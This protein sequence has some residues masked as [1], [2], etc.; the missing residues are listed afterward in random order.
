V[1]GSKSAN[2]REAVTAQ[3][4]GSPSSALQGGVPGSKPANPREAV[5]AQPGSKLAN[6]ME[7]VIAQCDRARCRQCLETLRPVTGAKSEVMHLGMLMFANLHH[8]SSEVS[9]CA[10]AWSPAKS[11]A[12][13][14]FLFIAMARNMRGDD[15]VEEECPRYG[16]QPSMEDSTLA[17][18]HQATAFLQPLNSILAERN[19]ALLLEPLATQ[20]DGYCFFYV[21]AGVCGMD[22]SQTAARQVFACALEASCAV[23]DASDAFEDNVSEKM[24]RVVELLQQDEYRPQ[25]SLRSPFELSVMDKFEA[26]LSQKKVLETRRF[27]DSAE[28]CALLRRVGATFMKLDVT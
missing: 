14:D 12:R 8:F 24:Q 13:I 19:M 6:P 2:P 3:A 26:L 1:S 27:G 10:Q 15:D 28:L 18:M 16:F 11:L 23:A 4:S 22:V 17:R 5:T 7:A 21:A 9:Q 25:I 20:G